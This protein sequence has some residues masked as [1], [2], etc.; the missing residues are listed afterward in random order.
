MI[1]ALQPHGAFGRREI[2]PHSV[3]LRQFRVPL[4]PRF[5]NSHTRMRI[6]ES[7]HKEL[8]LRVLMSIQCPTEFI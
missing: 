1:L 4:H 2:H 5:T 3:P 8:P 7:G 6:H